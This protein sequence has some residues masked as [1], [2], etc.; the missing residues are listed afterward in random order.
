[1]TK[2]GRV[3]TQRARTRDGADLEIRQ[4]RPDDKRL[5]AEGMER[6]SPESR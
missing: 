3:K 2:A 6:L 1:M 5:I 4:I